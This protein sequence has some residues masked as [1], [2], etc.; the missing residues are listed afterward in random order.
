VF[1]RGVSQ[2][3][4]VRYAWES[5]PDGNLYNLE[6]LPTNPFRTDMVKLSMA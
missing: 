2:P 6:G 1:R 5:N 3:V 4:A